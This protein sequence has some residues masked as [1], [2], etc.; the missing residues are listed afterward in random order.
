MKV[1]SSI[2]EVCGENKTIVQSINIL[3][4]R[5]RK[6]LLPIRFEWR[7]FVLFLCNNNWLN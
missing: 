6:E 7:F 1:E 2:Y 3:K 5:E 4:I